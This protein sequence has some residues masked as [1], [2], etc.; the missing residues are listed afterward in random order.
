MGFG[1]SRL[2][3]ST[4]PLS[5]DKVPTALTPV[6]SSVNRTANDTCLTGLGGKGED[7]LQDLS[8]VPETQQGTD[9]R[10]S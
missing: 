7:L 10:Q 3:L 9:P 2:A 5:L 1:A 6:T 4:L 8:L